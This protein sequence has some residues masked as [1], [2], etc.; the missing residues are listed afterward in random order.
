MR[1]PIDINEALRLYGIWQCWREVACRL[2][3]KTRMQF[4]ADAVQSAVRKYD[5]AER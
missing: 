4:T 1:E 3:R 5:K 2:A